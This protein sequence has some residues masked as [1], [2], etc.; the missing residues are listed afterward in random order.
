HFAANSI[1]DTRFNVDVTIDERSLREVYLPHF[2]VAVQQAHA[3]SVM[4]AYN[5][6]NGSYCGENVHLLHD[7]LKGEWAF[8]AVGESDWI[9]GTRSTVPAATAGLDVEMPLP[10]FYG[11]PLIDAVGGGQLD[12]AVI[13]G[14]VR[15]ILRAQLCFRLDT[16]PPQVDPS[17][18][19]T[20]AHIDLALEVAREGI[21]VLRNEGAV[22]PLDRDRLHSLVVVGSLAATANLGDL[23][24]S[25]VVP[26]H[27]VTPLEG[28][29][30]R[31]EEIPI[32]HI[33]STTLSPG[34]ATTV[35]A[36]D[37][38][39]VV[40]GLTSADEGEGLIT[41]GDRKSLALPG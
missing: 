33:P 15:R 8:Q 40:A 7:V 9:L 3:G 2:R 14:A 37:A 32:T 4:S 29:T 12:V 27:T 13:D 20:P 26:T 1:E 38:V 34:D 19:E 23:G 11:Q 6:V 24:S 31:A 36:A 39:V 28:I 41:V 17:Q 22:L 35:A 18:V 25:R 21:V 10:N 16:D 5:K 30:D